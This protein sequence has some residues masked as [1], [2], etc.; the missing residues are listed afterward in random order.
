[1]AL[2]DYFSLQKE[3]IFAFFEI[4][5]FLVKIHSM[6]F[7]Y[8]RIVRNFE[9]LCAKVPKV[10][11]NSHVLIFCD[12]YPKMCPLPYLILH[13]YSNQQKSF[14]QI[15]CPRANCVPKDLS[16]KTRRNCRQNE[17]KSRQSLTP[18]PKSKFV[19]I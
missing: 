19:L 16:S 6:K 8:F 5:T 11:S 18:C 17:T 2:N 13:S 12:M 1:M 9:K 10:I 4:S 15:V 14:L 3:I 7:E